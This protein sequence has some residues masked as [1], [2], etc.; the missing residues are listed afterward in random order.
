MDDANTYLRV[1]FVKEPIVHVDRARSCTQ[2]AM[3][4]TLIFRA[5]QIATHR[6]R[7]RGYI[8]L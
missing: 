6:D 2:F 7:I 5:L 1:A 3:R 8:R 4:I